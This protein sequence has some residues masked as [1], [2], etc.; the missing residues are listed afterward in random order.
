VL[1]AAVPW[2]L[3]R[4][5]PRRSIS[6][7]LHVDVRR[8]DDRW[9][10][11]GLIAPHAFNWVA[12]YPILIVLAFCAA[13]PCRPARGTGQILLLAGLAVAVVLAYSSRATISASIIACIS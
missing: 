8:R 5:G 6:Q 13:G 3:A 12:E 11:G 7:P 4:R 2:E 10:R 9:H 1:R